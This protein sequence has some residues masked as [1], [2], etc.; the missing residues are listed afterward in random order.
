MR[1]KSALLF[2][3]PQRKQGFFDASGGEGK[4]LIRFHS[5]PEDAGRPG[6]GKEAGAAKADLR[7]RS[8][9]LAQLFLDGLE[10]IAL[11]NKFERDVQ[12]C[13]GDPA[14]LGRKAAHSFHE[15][16]NALAD[17]VVEIDGDKKTHLALSN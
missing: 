11:P 8:L 12:R 7:L 13:G 2:F 17:R 16:Q 4:M 3:N 15:T 1:S 14:H 6:S 10:L 9:D 5:N